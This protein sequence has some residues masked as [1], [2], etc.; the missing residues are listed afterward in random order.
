MAKP[1]GCTQWLDD[2]PVA[3][4]PPLFGGGAREVEAGGLAGLPLRCDWG[5]G[6]ELTTANIICSGK[7]L[8]S[9]RLVGGGDQGVV[10]AVCLCVRG[11]RG[12]TPRAGSHRP[13]HARDWNPSRASIGGRGRWGCGRGWVRVWVW[14][15]AWVWGRGPAHGL[16]LCCDC[17]Y[18]TLRV[19]PHQADVH[20]RGPGWAGHGLLNLCSPALA[21]PC[22]A[23]VGHVAALGWRQGC[24]RLVGGPRPA[25]PADLNPELAR[26]AKAL[27]AKCAVQ[28]PAKRKPSVMRVIICLLI[29]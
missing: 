20:P 3:G 19:C 9:C 14:V 4:R 29:S 21:N 8:T 7:S 12:A 6:L 16:L 25:A 22:L 23:T 27:P 18:R 11:G 5:N 17:N 13:G 2:R 24:S 10:A 28:A 26:P 1:S 15:R